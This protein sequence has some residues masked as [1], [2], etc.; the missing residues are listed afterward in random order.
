MP[1]VRVTC[2]LIERERE[3]L[4]AQRPEGKALA[5]KWEFPGGKVQA[6]ET[7]ES[8]LIRE[9][10]EELECE[11]VITAPMPPVTHAYPECVIELI[12]FRCDLKNGEPTALEHAKLAWVSPPA[13]V[14][15]DFADADRPIVR[16]YLKYW[17]NLY[18]SAS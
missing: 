5:G 10:R 12:P 8:C 2:A 3:I 1:P 17:N 6:D 11:V 9:I 14:D 7:P 16:E 18:G 15:L 13:L 4:V